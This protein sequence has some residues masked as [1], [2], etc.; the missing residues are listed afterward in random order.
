MK[1]RIYHVLL[2]TQQGMMN[3]NRIVT[4]DYEVKIVEIQVTTVE[5]QGIMT[6]VAQM[7]DMLH[8]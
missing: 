8:A 6:V 3:E 7:N 4:V 2:H 5:Y 1:A